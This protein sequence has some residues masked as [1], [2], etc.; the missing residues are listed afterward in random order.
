[1]RQIT[2]EAIILARYNFG[3]TDR[4]L[5][6]LTSDRG[7]LRLIAK[8]VRKSNSKLAGSIELFSVCSIT[9]IVGRGDM[10]TLVS[11]RIIE[12]FESIIKDIKRTMVGYGIL[13]T[14]NISTEDES[15]EDYFLLL[16]RTLSALSHQSVEISVIKFWAHLHML[17]LNGH[18]PNFYT[19]NRGRA[20]ESKQD[21]LFDFSSMSFVVHHNGPFNVGHIKVLRL[22]ERAVEPKIVNNIK[23]IRLLLPQCE[24][25]T[26]NL[27]KQYNCYIAKS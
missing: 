17:K 21:Y 4:I 5:V 1:M 22:C 9:Y 24:T 2:T 11:A 3:E 6:V 18:M 7:K 10:H 8:G 19:D 20:L 13:K 16:Q 14:I 12:H 25:I 23:D 26:D 27:S 15:G